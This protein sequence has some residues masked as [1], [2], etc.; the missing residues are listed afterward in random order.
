MVYKILSI[1][2]GIKNLAYCLFELTDKDNF[3]IIKWNILDLM[4]EPVVICNHIS[5]KNIKCKY[6]AILKKNDDKYC[7]THAKMHKKYM[8]KPTELAP[9]KY[10]KLKI[11]DLLQLASRF[12]LIS[13]DSKLTKTELIHK[14][15]NLRLDR[16]YDSIN[17]TK[18]KDVNLILL[19]INLMNKF[20]E[21]LKDENIDCIIIENQIAPI[22]NRMSTIQGMITQYFI[23]QN[24]TTIE[25]ISSANKLKYWIKKKTT[26]NERKKLGIQITLEL[27]TINKQ[28]KLWNNIF[29]TSKKKDDLADCFLQAIWYLHN[30]DLINLNKNMKI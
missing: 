24:I 3:K 7:K 6:K 5:N 10:K 19:G 30:N 9:V 4:N 27:I 23:M 18:C 29:C 28:F 25:F 15:D 13:E 16:C 14:L 17:E 26:Y 21:E 8:I 11:A 12:N 1:D 2:V 22:A 20:N